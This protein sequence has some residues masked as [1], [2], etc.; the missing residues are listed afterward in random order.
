MTVFK[1]DVFE[2][3]D[4]DDATEELIVFLFD[5]VDF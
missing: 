3:V 5:V 2:T 1:V 4:L